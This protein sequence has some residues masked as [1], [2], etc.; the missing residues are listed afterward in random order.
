MML[1]RGCRRRRA[2]VRH[3]NTISSMFACSEALPQ[4]ATVALPAAPVRQPVERSGS[5]EL[6]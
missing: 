4:F 1:C 5:V 2:S 3:T 6:R